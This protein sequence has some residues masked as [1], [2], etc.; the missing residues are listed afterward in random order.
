MLL[1]VLSTLAA[2]PVDARFV[3]EVAE[4]P[5]AELRVTSDGARY[6]YRA[7]HFLE[8]GPAEANLTFTLAELPAPPE[9]LTLVTRPAPG[10]RDVYEERRGVLE[11]LCVAGGTGTV[12]GTLGVEP[13][14][15]HYDREARLLD[16][17]VGS[18]QWRA[19]T[20]SA[21]PPPESPFVRG[22]AVPLGA[23][24][25]EPPIA[26]ARWMK[27]EG[28]GDDAARA[29]CLVL[30]RRALEGH[31]ERRLAVGLVIE[32][33]RAFPHAW[34]MEGARALDPSVA[35]GDERLATRQYVEVPRAQSGRFYL[36]LFDGA[37]KL[38]AK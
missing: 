2:T 6:T 5:V 31:P 15:A 32:G 14:V 8:E 33:A 23:L 30:A 1:L 20:T 35:P 9:V 7:T 18:A 12:K 19:A 38:V 17:K 36:Q 24:T 13:F 37:V 29:R 28:I 22:V 21:Q 4:L 27:A 11:K 10:C 16:I 3:L 34:V 25:F 26:G